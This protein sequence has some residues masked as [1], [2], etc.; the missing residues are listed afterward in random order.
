MEAASADLVMLDGNPFEE[1]PC[2]GTRTGPAPS[3]R[4]A[5]LSLQ[6]ECRLPGAGVGETPGPN[7]CG[8]ATGP[9]LPYSTQI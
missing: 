2:F 5:A 8:F 9:P 4:L 3:S 1:P 7:P 6:A